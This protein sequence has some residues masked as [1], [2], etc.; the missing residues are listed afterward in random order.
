MMQRLSGFQYSF[1]VGIK[2]RCVTTCIETW[3][4]PPF[5]DLRSHANVAKCV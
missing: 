5:Q 1:K 2:N 4:K 3:E